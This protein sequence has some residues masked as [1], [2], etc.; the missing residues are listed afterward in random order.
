VAKYTNFSLSIPAELHASLKEYSET[1]CRTMT[2]VLL[3]T[4][5]WRLEGEIKGRHRC[6]TGEPCAL[7]LLGLG[8]PGGILSK[9]ARTAGG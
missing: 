2:G 9:G 5:R 3:E 6:S 4:L 1:N 7:P 8:S